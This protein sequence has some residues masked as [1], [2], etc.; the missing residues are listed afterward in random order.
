MSKSKFYSSFLSELEGVLNEYIRELEPSED[1]K[2]MRCWIRHKLKLAIEE[3]AR[4]ENLKYKE[5]A[6]NEKYKIHE[7]GSF[8]TGHYLSYGDLD[9]NITAN[10]NPN[11]NQRNPNPNPNPN[12]IPIKVPDTV[13]KT[14]PTPTPLKVLES[15][16]EIL[17][18]QK[19][20][21]YSSINLVSD[22]R[23]HYEKLVR[24]QV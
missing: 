7:F 13:P 11:P 23:V 2:L 17:K 14:T 10:P 21:S 6:R 9:F 4:N 20:I 3:S 24:K 18:S 8:S 12:P 22:T 16:Q 1:D 5:S 19:W 15:L